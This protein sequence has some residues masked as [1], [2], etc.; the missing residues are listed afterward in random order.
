V[1]SFKEN[2]KI[3]EVPIEEQA[4]VVITAKK[5]GKVI[6]KSAKVKENGHFRGNLTFPESGKWEILIK[7]VMPQHETVSNAEFVKTIFVVEGEKQVHKNHVI[8]YFLVGVGIIA[9]VWLIIWK[10]VISRQLH[11]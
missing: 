7:A 6:K 5:E 4:I 8:M 3:N 2:G 9:F 10:F 1:N 11:N